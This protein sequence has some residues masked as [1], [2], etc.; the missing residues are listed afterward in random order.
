[1]P[2]LCSC[3]LVR[4]INMVAEIMLRILFVSEVNIRG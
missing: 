2:S 4:V 3:R 1:M